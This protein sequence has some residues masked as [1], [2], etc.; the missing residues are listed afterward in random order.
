MLEK[1]TKPGVLKLGSPQLL[2]HI[3]YLNRQVL[4]PKIING[5]SSTSAWVLTMN[6]TPANTVCNHLNWNLTSMQNWGF[7]SLTFT[8]S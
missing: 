7:R 6:I 8:T 5:D 2:I 1:N 3:D 4:F